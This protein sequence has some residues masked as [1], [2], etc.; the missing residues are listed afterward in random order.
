[1]TDN[2]FEDLQAAFPDELLTTLHA[3]GRLRIERIVSHG[4]ASPPGFWYDQSQHE[5][6]VVLRG[7]AVL[8]IEGQSPVE[9]HAGDYLYLAAHQK[10]RVE[11]TTPDEPTIWLAVYYAEAL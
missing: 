6:V 9:L 7:A 5:W 11:W 2:L 10:H 4:Q 1:M 3:A 8:R